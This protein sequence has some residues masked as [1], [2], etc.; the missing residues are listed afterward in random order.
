[1][2]STLFFTVI[3]LLSMAANVMADHPAPSLYGGEYCGNNGFICYS[4]VC[5]NSGYC[6]CDGQSGTRGCKSTARYCD[7]PNKKCVVKKDAGQTCAGNHEC[8]SGKCCGSPKKCRVSSYTCPKAQSFL[9]QGFPISISFE[10]K[11]RTTNGILS[12]I[13]YDTRCRSKITALAVKP[14]MIESQSLTFTSRSLLLLLIFPLNLLF[15]LRLTMLTLYVVSPK[16]SYQVLLQ[17]PALVCLLSVVHCSTLQ[18]LLD[19]LHQDILQK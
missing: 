11:T 5:H 3:G 10:F 2:K 7:V 12:I 8:K 13:G 1:M 19:T 6:G 16:S 9:K 17:H 4:Q 18:N 14:L 15:P